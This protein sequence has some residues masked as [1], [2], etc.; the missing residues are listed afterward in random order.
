MMLLLSTEIV[1]PDEFVGLTGSGF[2]KPCVKFL[3]TA[4]GIRI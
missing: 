4:K 1:E 2:D 3:K